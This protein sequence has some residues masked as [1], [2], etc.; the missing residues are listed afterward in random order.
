MRAFLIAALLLALPVAGHAQSR[1]S[2]ASARSQMQMNECA[3]R[4]LRAAEA[5]MTQAYDALRTGLTPAHQAQLADAQRAWTAF[6]AAHCNFEGLE[7]EGGSMQPMVVS[8]CMAELTD[9]R[10]R[11]LRQSAS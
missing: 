2:C 8:F 7:A 9:A 5:R 4:E 10:T 11:Q 6:R 3:A 1:G